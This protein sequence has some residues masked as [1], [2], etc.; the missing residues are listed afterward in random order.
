MKKM[1]TLILAVALLATTLVPAFAQE[2]PTTLQWY[3]VNDSA[4]ETAEDW[5][6][7][8]I[9][10]AFNVK[11]ELIGRPGPDQ[12][13]WYELELAANHHFDYF[14]TGGHSMDDYKS[15]IER[16]LVLELTEEMIRENM[17][18]LSAYY[19]KYADAFGGNVFDWYRIDGKIYSI[20]MTRP[21]DA[22]RN[23]IGIRGDW[24][25]ELGMKVP[26]TLTEF[27][28]VLDAF[29]H[30]DPDGNGEDDTYGFTGVSWNAFSMSPIAQA[31]GVN[32][33]TWYMNDEGKL[34]YGNVQPEMKQV[35]EVLNRWYK[36]G[37]FPAE[38]WKQDW[39]SFRSQMTS[40]VAGMCVQ[41]Y[42]SFIR[43]TDG[44]ALS[45]LLLTTP[46]AWFE[47]SP[48]MVGEN[49]D[50][51][52]LQFNPVTFAGIMFHADLE[53]DM[54]KV[55]KYMQV[56]DALLYDG[57]WYCKAVYGPKDV[58]YT[59]DEE[60]HYVQV[61]ADDSAVSSSVSGHMITELNNFFNDPAFDM[62]INA[63]AD[64]KYAD[65]ATKCYN[66]AT[67][68]YDVTSSLS[69][70]RPM[71]EQY[72]KAMSEVIDTY[73]PE[74]IDG[75]RPIDDFDRMVEEWYAAGGQEVTDE[76]NA[77]LGK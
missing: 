35:L 12:R 63:S 8:E 56:M 2:A 28:E 30:D 73:L 50:Y 26:T 25:E 59:V 60:G 4:T 64:A 40:G 47:V 9:E 45:D 18:R 61:P 75:T 39:D 52:C 53:N 7:D 33:D 42:D 21:G 55:K 3:Y 23:V 43:E 17:P 46:G 49:G 32:F 67:G 13:E 27:E 69:G 37:Y 76:L 31:F 48:G 77:L 71:N 6:R 36:A 44:W 22:K 72:E 74:I 70:K 38:F 51:G 24:L 11:L 15:F 34:V 65:D 5:L 62:G 14:F 29:T 54:D 19:D 41:S 68:I 57:D 10:A 66:M 16:G 58:G 1:L 20:P